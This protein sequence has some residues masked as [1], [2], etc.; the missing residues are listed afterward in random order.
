[1]GRTRLGV[2][3]LI[4]GDLAREIDGL[5]R[6]LADPALDRIPP[7]ITLV[8][9]VN[10]ADHRMPDALALLRASATAVRGPVTI[11]LGPVATFAPVNPVIFL[12]VHGD[13]EAVAA[14]RERAFK[15]PLARPVTLAFVPHVTLADG[16]PPER[17]EAALVALAGF[18]ASAR[19]DR[20]HL[21]AQGPGR[22][23]V[24]VADAAF[25]APVVVG[26]GG[27]E[28]ELSVTNGVDPEVEAFAAAQRARAG[29]AFTVTARRDGAVVAMA[30]GRVLGTAAVLEQ[31]VVDRIHRGEGI[32]SHLVAAVESLAARRGCRQVGALVPADDRAAAFLV[33][34]GW[35][36]K[37]ARR[38]DGGFGEVYLQRSLSL[39]RLPHHG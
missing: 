36:E 9:P 1:M 16:A 22:V 33:G 5:R 26:R 8:P 28:L 32:G 14:L 27:L 38:T 21:L 30:A 19:I 23:W 6:A 18:R 3:L 7:H 13:L 15:A 31:L 2:V 11:R 20:V 24:P 29:A 37:P 34:R 4:K 10:V 12:D 25:G 17:I 39:N 35:T